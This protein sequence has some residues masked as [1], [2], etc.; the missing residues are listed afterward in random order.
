MRRAL[1]AGRPT[2]TVPPGARGPNG[3]Y[4]ILLRHDAP[5][6]EPDAE[7]VRRYESLLE[8]L[9]GG[10]VLTDK[11]GRNIATNPAAEHILDAAASDLRGL[12]AGSPGYRYLR[13]DGSPFPDE[14]LP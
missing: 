12:G 10:V 8:T 6:S 9:A 5:V 14:E 13:E 3:S 11:D 1:P 4:R 2:S 7:A